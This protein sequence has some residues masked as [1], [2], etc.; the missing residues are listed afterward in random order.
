MGR[1][2]KL[3]EEITQTILRLNSQN[4]SQRKIAEMVGRSKTAIS[5]VLKGNVAKVSSKRL[6]RP[7]KISDRG[8]RAIFNAVRRGS[9]T[10]RQARDATD[11]PL[12]VRRV[13]QLLKADP[14]MEYRKLKTAPKLTPAH[15]SERLVF[16]QKYIGEDAR[17]WRHIIYS[18]EKRFCL[19]G[20]D[21]WA[22]HWHDKRMP[23]EVF[24]TRPRHGGGIMVWAGVSARGTTKLMFV[25]S[26]MD[27]VAYTHVLGDSLMPH[28]EEKFGSDN[29][30]VYFQQDNASC[31]T[32]KYTQEW[33]MEQSVTVLDWPA[34]SADLNIIEN[35][36]SILARAVYKNARQFETL[37]DLKECLLM[38][39]ENLNMKDVRNLI[40]SISKRLAKVIIASGGPSGY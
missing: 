15:K 2:T 7:P 34:K 6:G 33:L 24:S 11:S 5:N 22:Y 20:P 1:G 21:G 27:S 18:D 28:I 29:D 38:E 17:F 26:T 14:N 16:A 19:D 31:H 23:A 32:A 3:S 8:V 13:Q 12:G 30:F 35:V 40:K 4:F 39:W 9:V 37:D 25:T 36:W 10:A